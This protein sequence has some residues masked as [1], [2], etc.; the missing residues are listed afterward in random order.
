MHIEDKEQE[1]AAVLSDFIDLLN[2]GKN[3]NIDHI[4]EAFYEL[5][6]DLR[7]VLRTAKLLDDAFPDKIA[8]TVK[9]SLDGPSGC[10]F[11][12]RPEEDAND[13]CWLVLE[14]AINGKGDPVCEGSTYGS[15]PA[16][17]WCPLRK[18]MVVVRGTPGSDRKEGNHGDATV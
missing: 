12:W 14:A 1:I 13:L 3:P 18:G 15:C 7:P 4:C 9:V 2:T 17:E 10:P 8:R 5:E 11:S 16:P 6:P